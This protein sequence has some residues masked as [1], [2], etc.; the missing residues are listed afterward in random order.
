MIVE[1]VKVAVGNVRSVTIQL[2][3]A[4]EDGASRLIKRVH[5][6]WTTPSFH[7][8]GKKFRVALDCLVIPG[9]S[10]NCNI[11][12]LRTLLGAVREN[13]AILEACQQIQ[14]MIF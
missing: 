4:V 13:M 2:R 6:N 10:G 1:R 3:V 12:V 8:C 14:T 7:A 5:K 11:G 9:S